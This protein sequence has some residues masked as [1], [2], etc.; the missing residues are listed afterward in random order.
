MTEDMMRAQAADAEREANALWAK[1]DVA[2]GPS[3]ALIPAG[4]ERDV[5]RASDLMRR[6]RA[7]NAE[8]DEMRAEA[9]P[10]APPT[11]SAPAPAPAPIVAPSP[12]AKT[13]APVET[14]ETVAARILS[15]DSA[16]PDR[17]PA[18]L[19]RSTV[20]AADTVE[21]VVARIMNA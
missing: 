11:S 19:G 21:A 8:A 10:V 20:G 13:V 16:A 7:L 17:A 1:I 2:R 14:A 9:A 4:C 15:S 6:A 5:E 18:P 3:D 12:P